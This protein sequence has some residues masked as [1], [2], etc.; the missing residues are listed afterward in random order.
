VA[1]RPGDEPTLQPI[2][3]TPVAVLSADSAEPLIVAGRD[4]CAPQRE[5]RPR[6]PT[7]VNMAGEEHVEL[8][9]RHAERIPPA[10]PVRA[11]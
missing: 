6:Q 4:H 7:P 11:R 3:D 5:F 8:L 10:V 1:A 2:A 9:P